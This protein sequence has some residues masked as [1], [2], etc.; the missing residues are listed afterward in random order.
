MKEFENNIELDSAYRGCVTGNILL[1]DNDIDDQELISQYIRAAG[2][3]VDVASNKEQVVKLSLQGHYD[4]IIIDLPV[5][6]GL[7][8]I[9][10]LKLENQKAPVILLAA[11]GFYDIEK[12]DCIKYCNDFLT[13][14]VN[15]ERFFKI[16]Q[17]YLPLSIDEITPLKSS[18]LE[19]EPELFDL[20][21][22]YV[23]K[24]PE[25]ISRLKVAFD[26]SDFKLFEMLLHDIKSTGGTYGFMLI[27]DS[28]VMIKIHLNKDNKQEIA[29]LLDELEALHQR[30]VLALK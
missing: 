30:M 8:K 10:A 22:K 25:M 15:R 2:A 20:V 5:V 17:R 16:L 14:P 13:K 23:N 9:E 24:Y 28:A 1:V 3:K 6:D 7:E 12:N 29:L 11:S 4:L 27:T 26:N 18:L 19:S 21:K